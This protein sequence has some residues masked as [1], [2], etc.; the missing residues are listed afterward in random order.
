ML[1]RL[2]DR[3]KKG[4]REWTDRLAN[5]EQK[6]R[7]QALVRPENE[8]GVDPFGYN[9]DFSLSAV[10]P[11]LWLYRNYFRVETYG[12]EKVPA[13]RVLLVSNHSGQLPLDGAMIGVSLMLEASPPR[14]MRSMVEKWVPSLPY[15]STFM[16]RM[17]QIVGT[18][19]NCRRLLE[20]DEAILVFPEGLR[21][22]NKLWPQRYQLQEFG[23]GFMR[24]ALETRTPIVP[25]AVVGAEEQAPALMDLKPVAKLLGFPSFPVTPTGLPFPLPTKYRLYYGD[26]MHF[27]GR[28]D[29][30]DSELD[31][32]VRTVKAAIQSMLHQGLKERRGVFW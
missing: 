15:V 26:P 28:P 7:M 1:E 8:Y 32:K 19:E 27:T 6:E 9:L 14:A 13:G 21:G 25:V 16:A 4:L 23:L 17:G 11:F 22:I 12:I 31:K 29:D 3:V 10:A 5:D 2:G 18:P 30:E 20:S 24:L